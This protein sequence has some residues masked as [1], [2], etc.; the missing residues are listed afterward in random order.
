MLN[1]V[2]RSFP[3]LRSVHLALWLGMGLLASPGQA[4]EEAGTSAAE[5][6][7]PWLLTPLFSVDPKLGR[8]IGGIAAYM[9]QFDSESPVSMAGVGVTYS[10]TDSVIGGLFSDLYWGADHHRLT[11][12][13]AY[14]NINNEYEDFLG[15]GQTVRTVDDLK[16]VFLRYRYRVAGNWF[17]GGQVLRTNYAIDFPPRDSGF[18]DQIGYL[19]FSSKGWGF[20][21]EMDGRN[22]VRNPDRGTY[23][24][25]D[26]VSYVDGDANEDLPSSP[27]GFEDQPGAAPLLQRDAEFDVMRVNLR[28]YRGLGHWFTETSES[29]VVLAMQAFG[30]WTNDAPISGFSSVLIPGYTRGNYLGENYND[31]QL[32]LRM[33]LS[34]RWGAILFAGVG[35]LHGAALGAESNCSDNVYPGL[36][37]GVS[38]LI[39]PE[40]GVILRAEVAKG[41]GDNSA[42]YL[43]F[44]HP[45]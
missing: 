9:P 38:W 35:C 43:R 20:V 2:S 39:K 28:H 32:D 1:T 15:T 29:E 42:M 16:S 19:G 27:P 6:P 4:E 23:F 26:T 34:R 22:D 17:L 13:V 14:G 8:N 30:R 45:F 7:S 40:S 37:A 18:G 11:A 44:G 5:A 41:T 21:A 36:G 25:I 10:N 24:S 12:A 33:P 3:T 31:I